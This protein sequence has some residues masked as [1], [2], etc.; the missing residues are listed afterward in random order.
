MATLERLPA[1]TILFYSST[2]IDELWTRTTVLECREA[3]L[4]VA[5]AILGPPEAVKARSGPYENK[6]VPVFALSSDSVLR[7]APC[8]TVVSASSGLRRSSFSSAMRTLI[9][10]PHSLVSL[11]MAYPADA[12]D[13]FDALF[14][15]GPHHV[16]EIS[17]LRQMRGLPAAR[18]REV[19]YGKF[20]GF[21]V[22]PCAR[23][24]EGEGARKVLLA[25]SWGAHNILAGR[26]PDLVRL[27]LQRGFELVVR[28]HPSFWSN[29]PALME[30]IAK[31]GQ[32]FSEFKIENPNAG[33]GAI[34]DADVLIT[35]YSGVAL[36][37]AALNRRPVVFV[38]VQK[39]M[40]NP[41][42]QSIGLE[43]VE[44]A[45]RDSLGI[46]TPPAT[47]DVVAAV[48]H[49]CAQPEKF[50]DSIAEAEKAFLFRSESCGKRAAQ[51]LSRFQKQ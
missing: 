31:A 29:E 36:E 19:G 43:P 45:L 14:A 11:H 5:V 15:A 23:P 30:Q 22:A 51:E 39:K 33:D 13:D 20:D 25:P 7:G 10:M 50:H 46:I 16:A 44:V 18:V 47:E 34:F 24:R 49:A 28:P 26:G 3:G 35:D 41:E 1:H 4:P 38:D 12:F 42:W 37:Y 8:E 6:G 40:F 32:G 21:G 17:A 2:E 9:H 48:E 27:L